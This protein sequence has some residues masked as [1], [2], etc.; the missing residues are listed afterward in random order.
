MN[1][2]VIY[3]KNKDFQAQSSKMASTLFKNNQKKPK[4]NSVNG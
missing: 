3:N 2:S 4:P 1:K